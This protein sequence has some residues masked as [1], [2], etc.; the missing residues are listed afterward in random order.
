MR[1][2]IKNCV[3][4]S[5]VD[6]SSAKAYLDTLWS[7]Q[8]EELLQEIKKLPMRTK[9]VIEFDRGIIPPSVRDDPILDSLCISTL[10]IDNVLEKQV[11]ICTSR[12][13]LK[14]HKGFWKKLKLLF[15]KKVVYT[16]EN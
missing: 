4:K 9:W 15:S 11:T 5:V 13:D 14:E 10:T 1:Y 12:S 16:L 6:S 3:P 7:H 8:K 2:E